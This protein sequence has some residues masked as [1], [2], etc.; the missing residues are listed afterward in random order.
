MCE[1]DLHFTQYP[2]IGQV[3]SDQEN[4]YCKTLKTTNM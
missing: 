1:F 4:V 2:N 3:H